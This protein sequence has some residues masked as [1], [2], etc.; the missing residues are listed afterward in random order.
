MVLER[1]FYRK[2]NKF[3]RAFSPIFFITLFCF[4]SEA[5]IVRNEISLIP[6]NHIIFG[7][8]PVI[9]NKLSLNHDYEELLKSRNTVSGV[10]SVSYH[11]KFNK[12]WGINL[13]TEFTITPF[14]IYSPYEMMFD[15]ESNTASIFEASNGLDLNEYIYDNFIYVLTS[16]I[17]KI[18]YK[19]KRYL[20]SVETGVKLNRLVAFPYSQRIGIG[21]QK[22]LSSTFEV[23][24]TYFENYDQRNFI[25]FFIKTNWIKVSSGKQIFI[26]GELVKEKKGGNIINLFTVFNYCPQR[27]GKGYYEFHYFDFENKGK[28]ELGINYFGIGISY[29]FSIR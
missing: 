4:H 24:N 19:N 14:S 11:R 10:V 5:Q 16:S 8:T 6:N 13:G 28:V 2:F 21:F 18:V 9:Y 15:F 20:A 27:I 25:S 7:F 29:G 3:L 23:F 1:L 12:G 26:E 22:D 17:D